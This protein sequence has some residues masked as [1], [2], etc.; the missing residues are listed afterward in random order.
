MS[1]LNIGFGLVPWGLNPNKTTKSYKVI[2]RVPKG[3][4]KGV[5]GGGPKAT[6]NSM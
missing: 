2:V 6:S 1:T 4:N 3:E 5:Q